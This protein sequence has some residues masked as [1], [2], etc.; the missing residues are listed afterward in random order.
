MDPETFAVKVA[1]QEGMSS[2][3][4]PHA[5]LSAKLM[6]RAISLPD[7]WSATGWRE[8]L[9][10]L[11]LTKEQIANVV[12]LMTSRD[13]RARTERRVQSALEHKIRIVSPGEADYPIAPYA[14]LHPPPFLY[15]KGPLDMPPPDVCVSVIGTRRPSPYGVKATKYMVG[16]WALRGVTIVSG[17]AAGIDGL[18]HEVCLKNGGKTAAVLGCGLDIC[19]PRDNRNVFD[20]LS[21]RGLLISEYPPLTPPRKQHFP[22]RNRLIS[23]LSD[24]LV[25]IEA[26]R[27][28][29]TMITTNFALDQGKEV[30]AL[31]GTI[32]SPTSQGTNHLLREGATPLLEPQDLLPYLSGHRLLAE[33]ENE[34]TDDLNLSTK[35]GD[36]ELTSLLSAGPLTV[37]E[38]KIASRLPE[39]VFFDHLMRH[40]ISG[41]ISKT[42][43]KYHLS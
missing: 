41:E 8:C 13:F 18:A 26:A 25:V 5:L 27:K 35:R 33:S 12:P 21:A 9:R 22:A 11:D 38:L 32:Y 2:L 15:L 40:E 20:A 6:T 36:S 3:R 24:A 43:G 23:V 31:P 30:L 39:E 14:N 7:H 10:T 4:Y 29:G 17:M 34:P 28:S 19:Y 16:D 42:A 37:A 1:L